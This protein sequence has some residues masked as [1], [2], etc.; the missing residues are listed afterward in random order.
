MNAELG[1]L[2]IGSEQ[3]DLEQFFEDLK[4]ATHVKTIRFG[5]SGDREIA[6]DLKISIDLA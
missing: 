6:K 1:T 5:K 2:T 3:K 4:G